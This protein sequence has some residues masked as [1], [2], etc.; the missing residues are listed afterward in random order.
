METITVANGFTPG[1]FELI[2][3]EYYALLLRYALSFTK[4]E[5]A[6]K[7][8]VS[9]VFYRCWA[10]RETLRITTSLK[11]YL[12]ASVKHQALKTLR[13]RNQRISADTFSAAQL[14]SG[15]SPLEAFISEQA[16]Q[17]V[18]SLIASLPPL[19]QEIL[20][21]KLFGL[22]HAE[23]A[24][25]LKISPRKVE[26]QL[27]SAVDILQRKIKRQ[28]VSSELLAEGLVVLHALVMIP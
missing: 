12:I 10:Q 21:L 24:E 8:V 6:A 14:T 20:E 18:E 9:E 17:F 3:K 23:V 1:T 27:N 19:Q 25:V 28:G 7:D 5:A 13:Q 2:F 15:H 16:T 22:T 4:E 26:Y 11:S